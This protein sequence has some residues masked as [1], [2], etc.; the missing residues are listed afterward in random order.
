MLTIIISY[1]SG[2]VRKG[3]PLAE[4]LPF[5]CRTCKIA[6]GLRRQKNSRYGHDEDDDEDDNG[7]DE[8]KDGD[9][10]QAS[11]LDQDDEAGYKS[12]MKKRAL[13][14]GVLLLVLG[15]A[16]YGGGKGNQAR[17]LGLLLGGLG[18]FYVAWERG[19]LVILEGGL[20]LHNRSSPRRTALL[21]VSH[22]DMSQGVRAVRADLLTPLLF[23]LA[24]ASRL[25]RP[26]SRC[27]RDCPPLAP[28]G[29][30]M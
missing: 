14:I 27:L 22:L 12:R 26:G 1:D 2:D 28:A 23:L 3:D 8:E 21:E 16:L 15:G 7:N 5:L 30:S 19:K 9:G 25:S 20:V 4:F 29:A 24:C 10:D 13:K 11:N 18:V 6:F 17:A